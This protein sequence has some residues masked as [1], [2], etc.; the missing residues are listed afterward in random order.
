MG[1]IATLSNTAPQLS[2]RVNKNAAACIVLGAIAIYAIVAVL[3]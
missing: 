2:V 1:N 3:G